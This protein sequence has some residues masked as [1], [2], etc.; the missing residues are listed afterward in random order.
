[1]K[2]GG[3]KPGVGSSSYVGSVSK[4]GAEPP[5][6]PKQAARGDSV[7]ISRRAKDVRNIKTMLEGVPD[8]R[9]EKVRAIKTEVQSG[10]YKVDA[11]K[12][13][14]KMIGRAIK[15]SILDKS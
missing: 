9:I 6:A 13:A 12:V 4:K 10:T 15:D 1:M 3:R 14:E 11:G 5:A 7:D 2:I 8:I